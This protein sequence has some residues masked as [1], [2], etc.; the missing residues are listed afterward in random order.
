MGELNLIKAKVYQSRVTQI[1]Y[2]SLVPYVTQCA[3]DFIVQSWS[4]S[5]LTL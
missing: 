1:S 4:K 3:Q 2:I 5:Q